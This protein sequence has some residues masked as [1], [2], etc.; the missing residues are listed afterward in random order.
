MRL[1]DFGIELDINLTK[2]NKTL[3]RTK[4]KN[5]KQIGEQTV[6]FPNEPKIFS[7][8][9][10]VSQK[11]K[12]GPF[13]GY[14]KDVLKD[15]KYQ[16]KT[17]EKAETKM[18]V[19]ALHNAIENAGI[20]SKDID[21][22][23]SGDLLAQIIS[24]SYCARLFDIPYMGIYGACSTMAE[25]L[26]F[27]AMLTDGGFAEIAACVTGSHYATA[28][29][30]YRGPLELG[31]QKQRY[32]QHTVTAAAAA[33]VG[34]VKEGIKITKATIGKV[35]DYGI[36]DPA[37]MGAA[38]APS[39]MSTLMQFFIDTDTK[40]D[41]YD[42]IATGDLGK[43]GSD[44]LRQLM[45]EKGYHLSQNYMDCGASIYG[46]DQ[47]TSEGGSGCG[48]G[49]SVLDAYILNKMNKGE[50]KKVIFA[51]TGALLSTIVTQ[52]GESM[53]SVTHLVLLEK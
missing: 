29:R 18:F 12:D 19:Y 45:D 17:F 4:A 8:H 11:E 13:A 14:F 48:C 7:S 43:L 46:H 47:H 5:T 36:P 49:A 6:I 26:I 16:E 10:I 53:P 24:S 40:P 20:T 50:Y 9:S 2:G 15:T 31:A 30:Q 42:L 33:I 27:S 41:D 51:A 38:M 35:E 37:N 52:Q 32:S 3:K 23:F 39:A 1:F 25:G 28:E 44:L 21:V 22:L 34:L